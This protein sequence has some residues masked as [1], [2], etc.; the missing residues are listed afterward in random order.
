MEEEKQRG[1]HSSPPTHPHYMPLFMPVALYGCVN[2]LGR[3]LPS[4]SFTSPTESKG[5]LFLPSRL[6]PKPQHRPN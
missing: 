2:L 1:G 4:A 3:C 6:S 5:S